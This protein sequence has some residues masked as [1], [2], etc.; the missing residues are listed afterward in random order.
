MNSKIKIFVKD[1]QYEKF[2]SQVIKTI[3]KQGIIIKNNN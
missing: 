1:K 2:K 3:D